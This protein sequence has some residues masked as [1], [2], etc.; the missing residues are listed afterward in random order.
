[1]ARIDPNRE[2]LESHEGETIELN[3][4]GVTFTVKIERGGKDD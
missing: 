2:W 1:M 3:W 4:P